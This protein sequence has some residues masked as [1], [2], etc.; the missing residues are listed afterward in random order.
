LRET[1]GGLVKEVGRKFGSE[2]EGKGEVVADELA[3]ET[4]RRE[5]I[6][7]GNTS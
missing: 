1:E 2:K 5:V 7:R 3:S 6:L 4:G